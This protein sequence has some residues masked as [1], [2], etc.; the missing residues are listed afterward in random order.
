MVSSFYITKVI[1]SHKLLH[2]RKSTGVRPKG[3]NVMVCSAQ[4]AVISVCSHPLPAD[5]FQIHDGTAQEE[6]KVSIFVYQRFQ[7][8]GLFKMAKIPFL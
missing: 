1:E 7:C 6:A 4:A 2:N 8:I 5:F 3:N